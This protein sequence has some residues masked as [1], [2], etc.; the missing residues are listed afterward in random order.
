MS[1]TD[2]KQKAKTPW[3][4][5][6]L[7]VFLASGVS[8]GGAYYFLS[9]KFE[10]AAASSSEA[11]PIVAVA[12]IYLKI[13]PFTVNVKSDDRRPHLLYSGVSFKIGDI[14][15]QDFLNQHM[16]ELRSRLLLLVADS[17]AEELVTTEG[18]DALAG[19]IKD[20]FKVPFTEPQPALLVNEV[21][22]TDFIVQ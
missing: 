6:A 8:G 22:F 15:T 10:S 2:S 16:T 9:K 12:P 13:A 18:K 19:K 21:L 20:I 7:M 4:P 14:A 3:M 1:S 11:A 5:I 17:K